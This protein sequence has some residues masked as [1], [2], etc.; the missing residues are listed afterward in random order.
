[1]LLFQAPSAAGAA[2]AAQS[3]TLITD[4][5]VYSSGSMAERLTSALGIVVFITVAWLLSTNRKLFPWRIVLWGLGLQFTFAL[6]I[7]RTTPGRA[8]FSWLNDAIVRLMGYA[9][10]GARFVFGNLVSNNVPVGAATDAMSP[11]TQS[12]SWAA[13]GAFVAFSVLPTI[14]FF[15]SLMAVLYYLGVMQRLVRGCAWVVQRTMK[16]SGAETLSVAANIFVGHTEAPLVI[17]PYLSRLTQ[18][19]LHAVMAAGYASV[20]GGVMAAYIGMLLGYFPAI[21]GHLI[22]ASVMSAPASLLI[23]KIMLPETEVPETADTH[24]EDPEQLDVNVIDAMARGAT[25]GTAL[26]INVGAMLI[27]FIGLLALGNGILG[28]IGGFF[29]DPSFS[30]QQIFGWLGAPI[31]WLMGTPIQDASTVGMLIGEKTSLNEFVAY[32]HLASL[33]QGGAELSPR[34]VLI[35]SYALCG[36]ANF[37]SIAVQIGGIGSLA[38]ER[39]GDLSRLG[40][41]A[42]I[43]GSL[44]TFIMASVVG[45]LL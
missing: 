41:R 38:P 21:G 1:M 18:S 7:L 12:T 44:A 23:S 19:E 22:A 15:S 35:A 16:T 31:A 20:A 45:I 33:L 10:E 40:L 37:G 42:M 27:A 13:T 17:R 9:T 24:A 28:W 43:A 25:E 8:V 11:L 30:L 29:G 39:R 34:A 32:L 14:I 6:L 2:A 4:S 5:L 3:P 36:F 26:A